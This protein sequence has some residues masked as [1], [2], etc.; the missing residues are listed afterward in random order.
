MSMDLKKLTMELCRLPGPAGFET[1]VYKY[2][3]IGR[4]HV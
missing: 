2:I 4:A 1:A 3:E